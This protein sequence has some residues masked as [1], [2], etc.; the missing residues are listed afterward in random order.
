MDREV[1][2]FDVE[3]A[4]RHVVW[5]LIDVSRA[6][7]DVTHMLERNPARSLAMAGL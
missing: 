7:A 5:S 3:A 1:R 6:G 4:A 2:P